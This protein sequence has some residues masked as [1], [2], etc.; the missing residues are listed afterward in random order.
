[1]KLDEEYIDQVTETVT[2]VEEIE[3]EEFKCLLR[4]NEPRKTQWD[5]CVMLLAVFNVFTIPVDVAFDPPVS[6]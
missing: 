2:S 5:L 1:M 6:I 4:A 3:K